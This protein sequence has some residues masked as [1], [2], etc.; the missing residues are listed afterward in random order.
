[1][2]IDFDFDPDLLFVATLGI[3]LVAIIRA[4]IRA[5]FRW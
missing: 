1:M 5:L 2:H 3:C 4:D